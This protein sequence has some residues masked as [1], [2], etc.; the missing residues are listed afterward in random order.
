MVLSCA[1]KKV[2]QRNSRP[3]LHSLINCNCFSKS[4]LTRASHSDKA[5]FVVEKQNIYCS[6]RKGRNI[7]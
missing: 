1:D 4:K 6:L 5:C 3:E 2:P 7:F